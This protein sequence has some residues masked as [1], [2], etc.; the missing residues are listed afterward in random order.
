MKILSLSVTLVVSPG[1][2]CVVR[3]KLAETLRS[4][5]HLEA[6][7]GQI[8]I[9]SGHKTLLD[10]PRSLGQRLPALSLH[11][12]NILLDYR[13]ISFALTFFCQSLFTLKGLASA[14]SMIMRFAHFHMAV[15]RIFLN[16]YHFKHFFHHASF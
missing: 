8:G 2:S 4:L 7:K 6:W 13:F 5:A 10:R 11:I 3:H 1:I 14:K 9:I 12:F 16:R 15:D